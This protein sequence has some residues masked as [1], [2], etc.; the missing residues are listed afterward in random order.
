MSRQHPVSSGKPLPAGA[1][2]A[3][4]AKR[5]V[6]PAKPEQFPP[7]KLAT[8]SRVIWICVPIGFLAIW[9]RHRPEDAAPGVLAFVVSIFFP[10]L[11]WDF[12]NKLMSGNGSVSIRN[13]HEMLGHLSNYN[14]GLFLRSW[15][16]AFT[17]LLLILYSPQLANSWGSLL[18]AG[19]RDV[20][21]LEVSVLS[22]ELAVIAFIGWVRFRHLPKRPS[23]RFGYRDMAEGLGDLAWT[24]AMVSIAFGAAGSTS[25]QYWLVTAG[26]LVPILINLRRQ[27]YPGPRKVAADSQRKGKRLSD[28]RESTPRARF[29]RQPHMPAAHLMRC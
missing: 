7:K 25:N 15:L 23:P 16:T 2:A 4:S 11:G 3:K 6:T 10:T 20:N 18:P 26:V 5:H 8:L 28:R 1:S 19:S 24:L 22:G 27:S 13:I 14:V 17:A 29:P 9:L 12:L 21:T